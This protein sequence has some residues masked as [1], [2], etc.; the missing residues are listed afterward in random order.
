MGRCSKHSFHQ[1]TQIAL[2]AGDDWQLQKYGDFNFFSSISSL[3]KRTWHVHRDSVTGETG[4]AADLV[5]DKA[6]RRLADFE[7]HLT[8][9]SKD[10]L[11]P[12]L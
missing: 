1:K 11:N 4:G 9:I 5:R 8:D 2:K 7:E 6:Y 12:S 3:L 10:W